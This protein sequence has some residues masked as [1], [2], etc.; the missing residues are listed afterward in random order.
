M[1][2]I[3]QQKLNV[4]KSYIKE[5]GSLAVAYSGGVDSTFL[6]K[7]AHDV[8]KDK[9]LAVTARSSTYPEREFNEAIKYIQEIGARHI[10]ITSEE[11]DIDGF[12]SNPIDRCYY[13]KKELFQKVWKVA[14]ENGIDHIADGSNYDDLNDYRPG[15]K[16]A[17]ELKVVSP[18]KFAKLTKKDIRALSK[19]MGL[20]TWDKPSFACLSSRIPYGELITREKLSMIDKAENFLIELGFR[21]LRVRHHGNIARIELGEKDYDKILN[22]DLMKKIAAKLKDIGFTY[23]T[24]DLEGYRTGS[25]N[26]VLKERAETVKNFV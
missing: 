16:A 5:L 20:P 4:L 7:V 10:V 3:L 1:D 24:L 19:E 26:E 23:V 12:S 25:M 22:K 17:Q 6:I 13:C 18:L 15:M 2:E 11:L 9:A 14:K 21:Q 8:L